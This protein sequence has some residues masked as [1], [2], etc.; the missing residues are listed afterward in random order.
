MGGIGLAS[1]VFRTFLRR[2]GGVWR[3][4][5]YFKGTQGASGVHVDCV[6]RLMDALHLYLHSHVHG[7]TLPFHPSNRG[8]NQSKKSE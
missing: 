7:L 5:A 6:Q 4:R 1:G 3:P 2:P 8:V